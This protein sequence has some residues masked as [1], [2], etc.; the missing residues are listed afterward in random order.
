VHLT[1]THTYTQ[2]KL[3]ERDKKVSRQIL[4]QSGY[5]D[6]KVYI[7]LIEL[8]LFYDVFIAEAINVLLLF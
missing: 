3:L 2:S 1:I 7:K 6:M 4:F 5:H 8:M